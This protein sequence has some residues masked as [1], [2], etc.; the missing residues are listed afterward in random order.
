MLERESVED[1]LPPQTATQRMAKLMGRTFNRFGTMNRNQLF[2][3]TQRSLHLQNSPFKSMMLKNMQRMQRA[4][5]LG[6]YRFST[7]PGRKNT[8]LPQNLMPM[9]SRR[10]MSTKEAKQFG[11]VFTD[12]MAKRDMKD[13]RMLKEGSKSGRCTTEQME[14]FTRRFYGSSSGI[15]G[16]LSYNH[17]SS[18]FTALY[19]VTGTQGDHNGAFAGLEG[20]AGQAGLWNMCARL[21]RMSSLYNV[22]YKRVDDLAD[23]TEFV[24]QARVKNDPDFV[25]DGKALKHVTISGHGNPNTLVLGDDRMKSSE[26]RSSRS[27]DTK[28]LLKELKPAL[29]HT[30]QWSLK[31][32]C[33]Q[34]SVFMA[35]DA[36]VES[37]R[38]RRYEE[39]DAYLQTSERSNVSLHH[40]DEDDEFVF[41]DGVSFPADP[42]MCAEWCGM[43]A[44]CH[45][46][47]FVELVDVDGVD[48][49]MC[50][51]KAPPITSIDEPLDD[52][53]D[54][55]FDL[56]DLDYLSLD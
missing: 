28:T 44:D 37:T 16:A 56:D 33:M 35:K 47:Q 43:I 36:P 49:G 39:P 29:I 48:L 6:K 34:A 18:K 27:T 45:S 50:I 3:T 26:L 5:N 8:L 13:A 54:L 11:K 51:L 12:Y 20:G 1:D 41:Y 42:Q 53:D 19:I 14:Q 17:P 25:K 31:G 15:D 4:Q 23:A 55:D 2:Q 40:D 30:G 7:F 32:K 22:V 24:K 9:V 21:L 38:S 52:S 46:F 10:L